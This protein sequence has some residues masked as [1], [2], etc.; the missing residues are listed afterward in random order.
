V[1]VTGAVPSVAALDAVNVRT[2]L[3]PVAGFG[4]KLGVTPVGKPLA[5]NVTPA[6]KPPVRVMVIVLVPLA[7]RLIVR[8]E[9]LAES[10]KSGVAGPGSAPNILVAPS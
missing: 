1:I 4:A 6:V 3:S 2:L 9:G 7:P 8:L 5:L 10:A